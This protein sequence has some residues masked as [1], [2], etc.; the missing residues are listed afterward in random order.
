MLYYSNCRF[1]LVFVCS[2]QIKVSAQFLLQVYLQE[3]IH[4]LSESAD[5]VSSGANHQEADD[6][7]SYAR[8]LW[9]FKMIFTMKWNAYPCS[10]TPI[11][12]HGL[13]LN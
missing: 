9:I 2:E 11:S 10:L 12:A 6:T 5:T 1:I 4:S 7:L 13:F 3:V 8:S